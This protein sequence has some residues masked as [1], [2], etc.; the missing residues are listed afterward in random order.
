MLRDSKKKENFPLQ[1]LP[2]D[3][4]SILARAIPDLKVLWPFIRMLLTIFYF[5]FFSLFLQN[6]A[7]S[8]PLNAIRKANDLLA[9]FDGSQILIGRQC[10]EDIQRFVT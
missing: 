5:A 6:D 1:S 3:P 2:V 7:S 9:S 8:C 10:H 4:S